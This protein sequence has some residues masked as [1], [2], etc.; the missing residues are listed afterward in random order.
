MAS[1]TTDVKPQKIEHRDKLGRVLET[2]QFVAFPSGNTLHFGK[3]E[4]ISPKMIRV[5]RIGRDG[6][7]KTLQS[8]YPSDVLFVESSAMT[9]WLLKNS[10]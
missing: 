9:W 3:V 6:L 1:K 4:K 8:K 7:W 2:G 10:N 5:S